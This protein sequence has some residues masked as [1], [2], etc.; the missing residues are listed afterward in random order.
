MGIAQTNIVQEY[1][2]DVSENDF[3]NAGGFFFRAGVAGNIK[4][5]PVGNPDGSTVTRAIDAT[6]D[7]VSPVQARKIFADGTT[8]TS[9]YI[10]Y[11]V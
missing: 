4:Y 3:E 9:I 7:F 10:G 2:I 1:A 5:Q 11:G 6:N 8:A